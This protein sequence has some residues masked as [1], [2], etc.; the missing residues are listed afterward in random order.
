MVASNQTINGN[1]QESHN[2]DLDFPTEEA[3]FSEEISNNFGY[4]LKQFGG[5]HHKPKL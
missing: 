1:Q 2:L 3:D 5:T 4:N